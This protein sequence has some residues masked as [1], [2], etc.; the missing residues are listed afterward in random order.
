MAQLTH[1]FLP[2]GALLLFPNCAP[3]TPLPPYFPPV[4]IV[5]DDRS[6]TIAQHGIS[7]PDT[8]FYAS[9][10]R[11]LQSNCPG[12]ELAVVLCG[13][14]QPEARSSIRFEA[15]TNRLHL[16]GNDANH[17]ERLAA[18]L[19][20]EA[21]IRHWQ[22]NTAA[23]S[24]LLDSLV[25]RYQPHEGND[26]T[27]LDTALLRARQILD[28]SVYAQR[29]KLLIVLSDGYNESPSGKRIPFVRTFVTEADA[30][31]LDII[32]NA[33]E[34]SDT[35]IFKGP[36]QVRRTESLPDALKELRAFIR[37]HRAPR[38]SPAN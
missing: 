31:Q 30:G 6:G 26:V 10:A 18:R 33:W 2:A 19:H 16:P 15:D 37:E 25:I 35:S 34:N 7:R 23:F 27:F 36:I 4:V 28:A 1:L 22:H 20:N 13:N 12:A 9:I 17:K 32:L 14:P 5:I 38:G 3:E 21:L 11:D 24:T 29:P 8:T